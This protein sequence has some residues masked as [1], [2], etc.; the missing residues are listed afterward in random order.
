MLISDTEFQP[1]LPARGA[2]PEQEY[3]VEQAL[4]STRAPREGSDSIQ[5][6]ARQP[7]AISTRAPREGSDP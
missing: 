1:A 4:I 3:I 7:H 5:A 2:T 6:P